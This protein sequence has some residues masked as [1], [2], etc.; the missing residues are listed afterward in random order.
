VSPA[1]DAGP[2]IRACSPGSRLSLRSTPLRGAKGLDP[3]CAR[4][5]TAGCGR[6]PDVNIV[7]VLGLALTGHMPPGNEM[8]PKPPDL[9]H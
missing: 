6:T 3:G 7:V 4:A 1:F 8:L 2:M 5:V 9:S